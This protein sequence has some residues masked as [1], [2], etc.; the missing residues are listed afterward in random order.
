[1]NFAQFMS[2]LRA[3]W[4]VVAA[5]MAAT[6]VIT[7]VVS[8]LMPRQYTASASVVVDVKPDPVSAMLYPGLASPAFM[9]TQIDIIQS[10]RVALRVIKDLKLTSNE[11][12]RRQWQEEAGGQGTYEQWLVELVQRKLSVRPSRESNVINIDYQAPDPRFAAGLANAFAQAY[13]S[14]TLELK[15]DPARQYTA[16]FDGRTKEAREALEKAQAKLSAFQREK[17]II[18]TDERLD[19]ENQRL[20]ELSSQLVA[21]QAVAAE[22]SSRQSQARGSSGEQLAE[23]LNN[24]VVANLKVDLNRAEAKLKELG[25]RY[26][27]RHPQVIEARA[28]A[29]ELRSRIAA[30]TSRITSGVGVTATIN[31]QRESQVRAELDAQRAKMLQ[32]KAVRDAGMV[33]VRDVE[34]AQRTYDSLMTRLNQTSLESQTTQ[35][36]ANVLTV[37]APPSRHS[38]PRVSLNIALSVVLGLL[39]AIGS[40]ILLELRDRRVRSTTDLVQ[41]LGLPVIGVLPKPNAK[42]LSGGRRIAHMPHRIVGLPAPLR[43]A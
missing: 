5:V 40:A 1:M 41:G 21:I 4:I 6:V 30:E 18:A 34:S 10:D 37:A 9:A 7:L 15:V 35:S 11:S 12:V 16:F 32:M 3:R 43:R 26:G 2:I 27:D 42:R 23:V 31:K 19:V 8:L 22:S 29:Q 13:I 38:S 24:P 20:N 14:T 25:V 28:N 39:L 17:G 36:Y 33:L